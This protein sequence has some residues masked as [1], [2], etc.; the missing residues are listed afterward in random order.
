MRDLPEIPEVP[1]E[2]I[3]PISALVN[4]AKFMGDIAAALAQGADFDELMEMSDNK[5]LLLLSAS[6]VEGWEQR[7]G[8]GAD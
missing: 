2:L 5:D 3:L 8:L 1:D 4:S 6:V 7:L